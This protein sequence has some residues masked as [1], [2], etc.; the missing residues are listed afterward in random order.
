MRTHAHL[1]DPTTRAT[2]TFVLND[3]RHAAEKIELI[4]NTPDERESQPTN[5]WCHFC[6]DYQPFRQAERDETCIEICAVCNNV[7]DPSATLAWLFEL[8]A[9]ATLAILWETEP[10]DSNFEQAE[11]YA[12]VSE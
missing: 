4:L 11:L 8:E 2:L 1:T 6:N 12:E 3:L 7:V 5:V 9:A 10:D